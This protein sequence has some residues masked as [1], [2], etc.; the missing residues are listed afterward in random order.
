MSLHGSKEFN[1]WLGPLVHT[2]S[3]LANASAPYSS[4][5]VPM[6][7]YVAVG[8]LSLFFMFLE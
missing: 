4:V 7:I 3:L 8:F 6:I 2:L 5:I 1:L